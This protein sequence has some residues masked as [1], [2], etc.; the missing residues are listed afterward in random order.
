MP[1]LASIDVAP[2]DGLLL[3]SFGGPEKP[4]DVVPLL[5]EWRHARREHFVGFYLNARNQLLAR[6]HALEVALDR[7]DGCAAGRALERLR[8]LTTE[9]VAGDRVPRAFAAPLQAAVDDLSMRP[10]P[11]CAPAPSTAT[12]DRPRKDAKGHGK[13]G[14]KGKDD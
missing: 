13:H 9:L 12:E 6:T 7:N 4:E 10:V 8:E 3:V 2:Y 1:P 11:G 14:H 5:H